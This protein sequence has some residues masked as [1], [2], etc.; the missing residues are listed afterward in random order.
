MAP[1]PRLF[2]PIP[3]VTKFTD[4]GDI[5][6]A[7]DI[8]LTEMEDCV[9]IKAHD[10]DFYMFLQEYDPETGKFLNTYYVRSPNLRFDPIKEYGIACSGSRRTQFVVYVEDEEKYYIGVNGWAAPIPKADFPKNWQPAF[11]FLP[12]GG[13]GEFDEGAV[14]GVSQIHYT[15]VPFH[16]CA[17]LGTNAAGDTWKA[18]VAWGKN[19]RSTWTKSPEN[20]VSPALDQAWH[21][22]SYKAEHGLPFED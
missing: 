5:L 22:R 15:R 7:E 10:N 8:G 16:I 13:A 14:N 20:P 3:N 1:R 17:Y 11:N 21:D 4:L 19:L 6:E 18:G 12:V 2:L 9:V